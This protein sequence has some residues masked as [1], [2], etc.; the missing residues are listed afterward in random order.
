MVTKQ[1]FNRNFTLVFLGQL[2]FTSGFHIFIPTLPIHLSKSGS[3]ETEIGVLIGV[4]SVSSLIIRPSVG[5]T[6]LRAPERNFMIA[7]SLLF[8]LSSMSPRSQRALNDHF[9]RRDGTSNG[10]MK[11]QN[12]KLLGPER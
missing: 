8:G 2:A 1:I 11:A 10:Q 12:Q 7:G 4:F 3:V 6:L 5:R 9:W